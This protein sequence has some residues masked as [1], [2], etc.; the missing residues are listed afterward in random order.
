[1]KLVS[2]N[3]SKNYEILGQVEIS[4]KKEIL[5]KIILAREASVSWEKIG[6]DIRIKHIKKVINAFEAKQKDLALLMCREMGMPILQAE[7]D[8]KDGIDFLNWYCDNAHT[9]LDSETTY[10][11]THELHQVFHEPRGVVAVIV[12]WNFPFTNFVWQAGQNLICGNTIIFKDSEEVPL[13]GKAI[14][15]I[16]LQANFPKGVFNEV[17]GDR[18]T[19]EYLIQQDIDA[20]CFTGS[21]KTGKSIYK[22]GAE[23]MIPVHIELGGS[24]PGIVF[25]NADIDKV[26][27]TLYKFKFLNCGQMCKGL[28][29][30]LV[31]ESR[32][33]EIIEKLTKKILSKKIGD[34][35]DRTTDIG[36]LVAERQV[37][38]LEEQVKDAINKGA[39]ILIG[40]KRPNNLQG[41]YYEPTLLTKITKDMRVWQEEVFGPVLPIIPFKT[42]DEA[43]ALANDTIYGLGA[44]V[45]TEDN[46][47]F[48]RVAPKIKSGMVSQNN[49]NFVKA[50]NPFGGYK[51]S[52]LGREHGKYGFHELTQ[53]KVIS[54]EK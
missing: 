19:G 37:A 29:R 4:S 7:N 48:A 31:H 8:L 28:K 44:Y 27:D 49:I 17:Y 46:E 30:L 10:E 5:E 35:E 13:F 24:S 52:G 39:K 16:F 45:F 11:N 51:K 1:M 53:I 2:T 23:K 6:L 38:L 32:M 3:P 50:C 22:I 41:A 18:K 14:E 40:G 43:I 36:P 21:T 9:Y 47:L 12:P 25:K 15:D 26:I 42:E 54:I 34:A 33:E 20:I